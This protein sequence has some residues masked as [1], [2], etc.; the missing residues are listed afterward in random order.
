MSKL[1]LAISILL[2]ISCKWYVD[3]TIDEATVESKSALTSIDQVLDE[4]SEATGL[5]SEKITKLTPEELENLAKEAQDDS[6]KSKKEIE[7]QKNTKE[8]KNI[9]VKDTPRLIKLIKNSSEKIDSVFQ[10]LINIGYNATYAAK[11]NLKNGLKMVKLLDEL[12]KISVSSNG[13]KSTQKYNKLKTV[14]NKFNAENSVSVSFK[15][16]SN[17]KIE[18]KKCIQTLMK[19]VETYFEGVCSELKNK[20]DG[21]YEKT[22]TTL[23]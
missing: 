4:I 11:S 22:L 8:S 12:L 3:N 20:N 19:N 9:E 17:S 13:D 21:E 6:E 14:V 10:T 18:T 7:D 1:I 23:S 15:E 16:H 5:S 2:I